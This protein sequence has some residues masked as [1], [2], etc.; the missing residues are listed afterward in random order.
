[1]I[2]FYAD[3]MMWVWLGSAWYWVVWF[4][5]PSPNMPIRDELVISVGHWV[6]LLLLKGT[7]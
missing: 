4:S 6:L 5:S 7:L 3:V 1:M 2:T